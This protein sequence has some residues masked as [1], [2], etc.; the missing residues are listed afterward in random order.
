MEVRYFVVDTDQ[1]LRPVEASA[2]EG[3]WI[4]TMTA[5]DFPVRLGDELRLVTAVCDADLIPRI[6]YFLR[7]DVNGGSITERSRRDV[8]EAMSVRSQRRYD[9]P[10]A[11][12]QFVGWPCDWTTQLAVVLDVPVSQLQKIGIGGPL[13]M[14]DL[15]GISVAKVLSYFESAIDE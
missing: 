15:W 14:S 9:H 6:C 7:A 3:L 8:Y 11:Q 2:V 4:G 13:V 1:Q 12:R 10:A 5:S